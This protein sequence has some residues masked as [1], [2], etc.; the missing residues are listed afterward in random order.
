MPSTD[1]IRMRPVRK[2][3]ARD[4]DRGAGFARP[5][6]AL[7]LAGLLSGA[8]RGEGPTVIDLGDDWAPSIFDAENAD[9]PQPYRATFVALANER[10]GDTR[11]WDAAR[12]DR[13]FELYGI[14]PSFSVIRARLLDDAR[15]A[16]HAGVDDTALR[17][18]TRP[19]APWTPTSGAQR[20][21]AASA[22]MVVQ[23][24]LRC[25]GL[26]DA[27]SHDGVFDARTQDALRAYQRRHML[28]SPGVLDDETRATLLTDSR[29]LDFRTLLRALRERVADAT[30]LIEDGSARNAWE[31]ILGRFIESAEYRR[32]MRPQPLANGAPDLIDPA[33]EVVARALGWTSPETAARALAAALPGRVALRLPTPP[34]YHTAA[35]MILRAEIDRGDIWRSYPYDADGRPRASPVENRPTFTLFAR[36]EQGEVALVRWATTIGGWKHEADEDGSESLQ[37]KAS[38]VGRHYWRDLVAAPAW[39]PPPTTPDHELVR[40][41][42][43]GRWAPDIDAVGPGYRSAYGLVALFHH[44]AIATGGGAP[45]LADI[46][47]RTHGSANYRSIL[48]GYSHGCHRLFNHLAL[49]LGAFVLAHAEHERRGPI[50]EPYDRII[51][52]KGKSLRLRAQ[53]RGYR[54]ELTPPIPVDVLPGRTVRSRLSHPRRGLDVQLHADDAFLGSHDTCPP[55]RLVAPPIR[56]SRGRA[57]R[58]GA[59]GGTGTLGGSACRPRRPACRSGARSPRGALIASAGGSLR[60]TAAATS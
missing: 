30:G 15:H 51:H 32:A 37:Y 59:D 40:R 6:I 24:H 26:L 21:E 42:P 39:Y 4:L 11:P 53:S 27:S 43:D 60:R 49:R 36:T 3:C 22:L 45:E 34:G 14:F 41:G 46:E 19:L 1:E 25:E 28:L 2:G 8:G 56:A 9:Q 52:W 10:I 7:A 20:A 58:E 50:D 55:P 35:P 47:I 29:E 38:P 13:Y 12:R 17:S 23:R 44:R 33:T 31:P 57:R 5:L 16:C 18:L 48:R 54:Y